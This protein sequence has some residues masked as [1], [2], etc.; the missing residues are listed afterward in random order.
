AFPVKPIEGTWKDALSHVQ[1]RFKKSDKI[2]GFWCKADL[3]I[4]EKSFIQLN[5]IIEK[6]DKLIKTVYLP[7]PGI[8]NGQLN[9]ESIEPLLKDVHK[10]VTLIHL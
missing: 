5:E 3:S 6:Y 9:F 2:P 10:K 8:N 7:L 4:I 1:N